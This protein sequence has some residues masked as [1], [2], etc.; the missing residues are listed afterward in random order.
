MRRWRPLDDR[1]TRKYKSSIFSAQWTLL[2]EL[3]PEIQGLAK[4]GNMDTVARR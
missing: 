3:L 4:L 1:D 2:H